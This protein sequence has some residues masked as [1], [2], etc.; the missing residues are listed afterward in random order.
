MKSFIASILLLFSI[1]VN[2]AELK[3]EDVVEIDAVVA[4]M[5]ES[6]KHGDGEVV[7]GL[8]TEWA[9]FSTKNANNMIR[10]IREDYPGLFYNKDY[11]IVSVKQTK[12][13]VEAVVEMNDTDGEAYLTK[14]QFKYEGRWKINDCDQK[15]LRGT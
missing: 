2:S 5:L 12:D 1:G 10:L 15:R 14:F 9:R 8:H 13:V 11:V 4:L 3:A 7:Y 6:L